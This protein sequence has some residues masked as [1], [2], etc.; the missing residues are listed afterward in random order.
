LFWSIY[1]YDRILSSIFGRPVALHDDD[2]DQ[3]ECAFTDND[4]NRI[5]EEQFKA[6]GEFC[7][8]AALIYYVRLTQILGRVLRELYGPIRKRHDLQSL[9]ATAIEIQQL[10]QDWL[11]SLPVYLNFIS[12]PSL[13]MSTI[14]QRQM[15][16]LKLVFAHTNLLLY[17]PFLLYSIG[18]HADAQ[19]TPKFVQWFSHCSYKST[20]AAC[21]ITNECRSLFQRRLFS[22]RFWLVNYAQFAAIGTL[23]MYSSLRL[24]DPDIRAIADEALAQFP[25]GVEG[26]LV[27]QRYLHILR[28]LQKVTLQFNMN[29]GSTL[30][31][32]FTGDAAT[33]EYP[34]FDEALFQHEDPFGSAILATAFMDSY[35]PE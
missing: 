13:A 9:Q 3:E 4:D 15:C 21:L 30:S 2:I 25:S 33:A 7:S 5:S 16:T 29:P 28:E 32:E 34:A 19:V 31:N 17:R 18:P 24:N 1:I 22:R 12:L 10:L 35:F 20:E 27:G 11:L 6:S 8:G 14:T 26:D 23:Y